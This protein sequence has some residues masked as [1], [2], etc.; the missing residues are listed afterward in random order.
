M[1]FIAADQCNFVHLLHQN[2]R[3]KLFACTLVI[4]IDLN[5]AFVIGTGTSD[6]D[7]RY[8][9]CLQ[10][11]D[12]FIFHKSAHQDHT[13]H[14]MVCYD[15]LK[16][17]Y[18]VFPADRKQ[19]IIFHAARNLLYPKQTFL[20][21]CKI[22]NIILPRHDHTDIISFRLRKPFRNDIR[23]IIM[24]FYVGEHALSCLP[25]NTTFTGNCT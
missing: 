23:L 6:R 25:A 5:H 3:C 13:V 12:L 9:F 7:K 4:V 15:T 10:K 16:R 22:H 19:D 14:F 17:R 2:D 1:L 8:I 18:I 21:K 11:I 24:F 20:K